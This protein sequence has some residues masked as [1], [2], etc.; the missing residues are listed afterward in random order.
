MSD[1]ITSRNL[2]EKVK[3]ANAAVQDVQRPEAVAKR[4][5][6]QMLTARE[7]IDAL[8]DESSFREIGALVE[9]DRSNAMSRNLNAPADGVITGN[10]MIEGREAC[11]LAQD[12]TVLGGSIGT[13]AD[14]KMWRMVDRSAD[15]ECRW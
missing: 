11:V 3:R 9:P 4:R 8:V 10:G 6:Q 12:F 14:R 5:D 7:R 15:R 1:E 2:L 13:V